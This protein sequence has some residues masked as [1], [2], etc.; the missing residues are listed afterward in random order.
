MQWKYVD[1]PENL[2]EE[3]KFKA[4][5]GKLF[6]DACGVTWVKKSGGAKYGKE[7]ICGRHIFNCALRPLELAALSTPSTSSDA[8]VASGK[9]GG[10]DEADGDP[11][12]DALASPLVPWLRELLEP[13]ET[14]FVRA[15]DIVPMVQA[16]AAFMNYI[17]KSE[18]E[19]SQRVVAI[20][21]RKACPMAL[22]MIHNF[23][24]G[25]K[26]HSLIYYNKK[27]VIGAHYG[28]VKVVGWHLPGFKLRAKEPI[29]PVSPVAGPSSATSVV[30]EDEDQDHDEGDGAESGGEDQDESGGTESEGEDQDE[31]DG[32][33]DAGSPAA[34]SSAAG[35]ESE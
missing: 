26:P 35:D 28:G 13:D 6:A 3:W 30:V 34:L 5:V 14:E 20:A 16:N 19:S 17:A 8:G 22:G 24:Q 33:S 23:V 18:Y 1:G 27:T 10:E 32:E 12:G 15:I 21:L 9:G 4:A 25:P 7:K 31:S 29:S 2:K 11:G